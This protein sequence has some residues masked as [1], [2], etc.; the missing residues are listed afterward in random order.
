MA[1]DS[2]Q[3]GKTF[4]QREAAGL[5]KSLLARHEVSYKELAKRLAG[6]GVQQDPRVLT[7][8]VNRGRF[9]FIFFLQCLHA[10]GYADVR[11]NLST[12][13]PAERSR[14][15]SGKRTVIVR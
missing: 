8:K 14:A 2:V 15:P 9:S 10:L 12:L 6:L 4:W 3:S 5:L 11:L 7:N 1:K 13:P